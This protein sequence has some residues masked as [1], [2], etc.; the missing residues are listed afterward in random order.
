MQIVKNLNM[1]YIC[2]YSD[3]FLCAKTKAIEIEQI[4]YHNTIKNNCQLSGTL[5]VSIVAN[6]HE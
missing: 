3:K 5:S 4:K 6:G 1:H 2:M